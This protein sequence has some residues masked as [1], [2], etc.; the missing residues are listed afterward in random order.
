MITT[1]AGSLRIS[2]NDVVLA[3]KSRL[4]RAEVEGG[5]TAGSML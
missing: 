2:S 3:S 1:P 4:D 5:K